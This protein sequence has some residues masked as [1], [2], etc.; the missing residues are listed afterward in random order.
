MSTRRWRGA[1]LLVVAVSVGSGLLLA[2]RDLQA[3][4]S[5]LA[6]GSHGWLAARLY[7]EARGTAT[8]LLRA[9][10]GEAR[11]AAT[12]AA[13][14]SPG[15]LVLVFP[16]Q[17]HA[18]DVEVHVLREHLQSGGDLLL[19]YSSEPT[20]GT[21]ERLVLSSFG[22]FTDVLEPPSLSP[23][24]WW[25]EARA[26]WRLQP[27]RRWRLAGSDTAAVME[28][29][30]RGWLPT[31]GPGRALLLGPEDRVV[32]A[33]WRVGRGRVVALPAELLCNARLAA[34]ANAALLETLR[35]WLRGPWRFDEYHHGLVEPGRAVPAATRRGFD[36]LLAQLGLLYVIAALA[37]GRRLGP[38]WRERPP[39]AGGAAGFLLRLGALH[40]RLGHHRAGAE[41][42]LRRAAELD[43]RFAPQ[44]QLVGLA[45]RGDAAALVAV[46]QAV[47]RQ[48]REGGAR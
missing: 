36:L 46:G 10:L 34:P 6:R 18:L 27:A 29:R 11:A 22:A 47:A 42:L 33:A 12:A 41:L 15:T 4:G 31:L 5:A 37:L 28:L 8:E 23:L 7:L 26:P 44:E 1:L 45:A 48:Q 17:A 43:R 38:A 13:A 2:G 39:L 30:R 32:A 14:R 21:V 35:G 16:W 24:A 19:A 25:R 3:A 9:P 20:P 40:H